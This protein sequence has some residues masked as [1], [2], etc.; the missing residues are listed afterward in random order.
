MLDQARKT[1]A[2]KLNDGHDYHPTNKWVLFG[3]HFAAIAGAGPLIGPVLAA[4]FG[5]LP[6][7]LWIIIGAVLG[8]AVHDYVILFASVRH[9]GL[10]LH[11]IA[12]DYIGKIAGVATAFA[13]L[14]IIITALAGLSIVVVNALAESSWGT[15]AI[16]VSIPAALFVG[17]YMYVLRKGALVEASIIGSL[18]LLAGVFFGYYIQGSAAAPYFTFTKQQLSIML[19]IYGFIASVLPVWLLLCPRDYLSSYLKIGTIAL[20]G[21]GIFF[22]H[23][24]LQ[25]PAITPFVAGGGPIIPGKVWPFVCITIACGAI[26]GFHSLISSGTT[27]KMIKNEADI[28]M[29]GFGAMLVEGFVAIMALIAACALMP[30]DYFAINCTKE[31]FAKLGMHAVNL[32]IL[33]L[34]VNENIVAR[35]GGAVSLAVGMAQIFSGIPGMK[36]LMSYWYHF[37]IMFEALFILTTIDTGTRV[38]RYITQ[39]MAGTFIKPFKDTKW[40]PGIIICSALVVSAWGYLVYNGDIATIWPMFGVANQLL[41][42]TALA[43]GTTIILRNNKKKAYGL[44]TFLPMLF[45]LATTLTAGVENIFGNYL[46]QGTFNG[47]LNAFLSAVMMVLVVII[48]SDSAV[49]WIRHLKGLER[50]GELFTK[51]KEEAIELDI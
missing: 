29:I 32:P 7:A 33:S 18:I 44:I 20:L 11:K 35:P 40:K 5:F 31:V 8:G 4:Q 10:S 50:A 28:R 27:P 15:F 47:N 51:E 12:R 22:V 16:A 9:N 34:L 23:P 48:V 38:A 46:P 1:P 19:P 45:M 43:I 13:V 21:V 14:F 39:E 24:V 37:A 2:Y 30:G 17:V 41:A 49:Q 36:G 6:G 42:T 3:H 26:S 25:M